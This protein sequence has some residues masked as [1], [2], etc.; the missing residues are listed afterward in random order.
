M[1]RIVTILISLF[2]GQAVLWSPLVRAASPQWQGGNPQIGTI[3]SP[4]E[5]VPQGFDLQCPS[6]YV[7]IKG[8]LLPTYWEPTDKGQP[9][10][11][12]KSQLQ[13]QY[14]YCVY[15]LRSSGSETHSSVRRLLPEGYS[16]ISD[17]AGR[18]KCRKD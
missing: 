11:L 18:L 10:R 13:E 16:C 15:R 12:V 1:M 7:G 14:F 9:A 4:V 3:H 8:E 6:A 2:I 17:G 5:L